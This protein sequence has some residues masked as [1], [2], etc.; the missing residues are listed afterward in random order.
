MWK[1]VVILSVVAIFVMVSDRSAPRLPHSAGAVQK[2]VWLDLMR[3][4][5]AH[6]AIPEFDMVQRYVR[7][8][9]LLRQCEIYDPISDRKSL[10]LVRE[11]RHR[12]DRTL[13]LLPIW[14]PSM[15][16][17]ELRLRKLS[18]SLYVA[19]HV[20]ER[21][22][23]ETQPLRECRQLV[24]NMREQLALARY[25]IQNPH[26]YRP[27]RTETFE[28]DFMDTMKRVEKLLDKSIGRVESVRASSSV[29]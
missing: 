16:A 23:E 17:L 11:A 6:D 4:R 8:S 27:D 18:G 12:A 3:A 10:L 5:Q 21:R 9:I 2:T 29:R 13:R 28:P 19:I 7:Q 24:A 26:S 22:A 20:G 25:I 1:R 14:L 15:D